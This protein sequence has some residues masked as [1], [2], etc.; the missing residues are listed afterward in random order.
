MTERNFFPE[1]WVA[2]TIDG[3][4]A[5]SEDGSKSEGKK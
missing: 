3:K 2:I 5:E 4:E 1:E